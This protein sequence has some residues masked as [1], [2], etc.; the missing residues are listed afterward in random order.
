MFALL[1]VW[2]HFYLFSDY[3]HL[4]FCPVSVFLVLFHAA[5]GETLSW[6]FCL[7]ADQIDSFKICCFVSDAASSHT[8]SRPQHHLT[9]HTS[10][11]T[12]YKHWVIWTCRVTS[13]QSNQIHVV[14]RKFRVSEQST[15]EQNLRKTGLSSLVDSFSFDTVTW[16]PRNRFKLCH[17]FCHWQMFH[18]LK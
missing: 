13:D 6:C 15:E 1:R 5:V 9:G 11:L 3:F 10:Q 14:E 8:M 12:A 4:H 17:T 7:T 18:W 16:F 2:Q